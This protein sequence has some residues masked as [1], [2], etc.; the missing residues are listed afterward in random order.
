M[1][2]K[3]KVEKPEL[4][5]AAA[6]RRLDAVL[7]QLLQRGPRE[8]LEEEPGKAPGDPPAKEASPSAPGKRL[9]SGFLHSVFSRRLRSRFLHSV[10]SRRPGSV[11]DSCIPCFPPAQAPF[12]IP[13]FRVFPQAARAIPAAATE[14]EERGGG[15]A[16][17]ASPK[18]E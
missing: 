10:F 5:A 6:R 4:E 12:P 8:P 13:A 3:V 14:E 9:H 11:P 2:A 17:A 16:G 1:A 15:G 7:E 18:T